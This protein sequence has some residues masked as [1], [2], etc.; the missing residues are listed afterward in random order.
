MAWRA[1]AAIRAGAAFAVAAAIELGQTMW[2]GEGLAGEI[3]LG[4]TFDGWD[5]VAYALGVVSA[6]A[7]ER[8]GGWDTETP[9]ASCA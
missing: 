1:R 8:C 7:W 9:P 2:R 4:S 6:V 5:F 3:I